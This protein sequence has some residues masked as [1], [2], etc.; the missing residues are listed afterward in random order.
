MPH[1]HIVIFLHPTSKCPSPKDIDKIISAEIP[2]EQQEKSLYELVKTYMI[3]GPCGSTNPKSS[4]MKDGKCSRY[5]PK[6]FQPTTIVDQDGF[7]VYRRRDNGKTIEINGIFLDN[8]HVV[9]YNPNLLLK[10][11]AHIN[12]E[13]CNQGASIKYLFKYN[14]KSYNRITTAI[15]STQDGH[16]S[17]HQDIDEIKQYLDCR[18]ISPCEAIW[19]IFS[20]PTH[21]RTPA[22]E[23]LYFHLPNEQL[24]FFNDDD[25]IDSLL[26][27]PT[28]KESMFTS[29]M[30][31]NKTFPEGKNLTYVQFVSQ[32]VYNRSQKCWTPRHNGYTIGRLIWVPPGTGELFYLRMMLTVAKGPCTY[33]DIRT[34]GEIQYPNFREACLAMGFIED[35][36]E[37]IEAI[38]EASDWGS[39]HC[40][41]KLFVIM[42]ISNNINR[43]EHVWKQTWQWLANGILFDRKKLSSIQGIHL[44]S[45]VRTY[46]FI[47][48]VQCKINTIT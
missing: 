9:P 40:L 15:V 43:P 44:F 32:F 11:Q 30:E 47:I 25:D 12:I 19:R 3:H 2:D 4:C 26:T 23:R 41:R 13:W 24:V 28:N 5:Y 7:P 34:I 6:N 35:D 45:L 42:L 10:Y 16:G 18:Y 36:M 22:V 1:A 39:G 14:K 17:H 37:S 33:E 31:A 46:H 21:G 27:R 38:R 8:R 48:V 29:W 20:F